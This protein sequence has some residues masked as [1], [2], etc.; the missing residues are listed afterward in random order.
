M[1]PMYPAYLACPG[2]SSSLYRLNSYISLMCRQ[3]AQSSF[4]ISKGLQ[5]MRLCFPQL[6]FLVSSSSQFVSVCLRLSPITCHLSPTPSVACHLSHNP[7]LPQTSSPH[8][9]SFI[10]L[11]SSFLTPFLLHI[12]VYIQYL[13]FIL[14]KSYILSRWRLLVALN[15]SVPALTGL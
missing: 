4:K 1:Y 7:L 5:Y 10:P 2:E 9:L 13:I 11:T 14:I 3:L 6:Q 15:F 12:T 8:L